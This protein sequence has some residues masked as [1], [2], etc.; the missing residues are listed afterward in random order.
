MSHVKEG[1]RKKH[2]VRKFLV[3]LLLLLILIVGGGSLLFY[4]ISGITIREC[5]EEAESIAEEMTEDSFRLNSTTSIYYADGSL[6]AE[7]R[8]EASSHY[9][10]YEEIPE[11]AVNA[12]VAIEDRTFWEN[13]GYDV[14]GII[15]AGLSLLT[16]QEISQGGSTI[17]QQLCKLALLENENDYARKVKEIFLARNVTETYE[18]EQIMEWYI[19]Y[20]CYANN[21]YG[22]KDATEAYLGKSVDELTLSEICYLC[23]I[24][25]SPEY[26]DPWEYPDHAIERRDKILAAM[27]DEKMITEEEYAYAVTEE[28]EVKEETATGY[29]P[30]DETTYAI[31]CAAEI[32]M[33]ENGFSIENDFETMEEYEAYQ[34]AY[35]A[36]YEE[37]VGRLYTDGYTIHTSIIP[38]YQDMIQ[39]A[40]DHNLSSSTE[41][42]ENGIYNLQGAVTAVDNQT[43]KVI[44]IVG[45]RTQE[46]TDIINYNR[47]YQYYR[48]PGSS[49]KPLVVYTPALMMGYDKD[50]ILTNVDVQ[51]AYAVYKRGEAVTSLSG[52]SYTL[53]NAVT[54][55]RNGCAMVLYD[56]ITPEQ[57]LSY[58]LDMGFSRIVPDDYYLSSCLGGLTYGVNTVEMASA[59]SALANYGVYTK[60][61]CITSMV[62]PDGDELYQEPKQGTI[63]ERNAA[64]EMTDIME[65]VIQSGTA[66]GMNWDNASD[67]P[68]AGKTGT[69]N[70]DT[71]GWFCGYTAPY[72][73]AAWVGKDNNKTVD[74]LYGTYNPIYI[75]KD[76]MLGLTENYEGKNGIFGAK[77]EAE[78]GQ[79]DGEIWT[80]VGS[81]ANVRDSASSSS[82]VVFALPGGTKVQVIDYGED[83][84]KVLIDGKT[85]Y[86]YSPLLI[87]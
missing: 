37:A 38:E 46:G 42:S 20:C 53:Q 79:Q 81:G 29:T 36:A 16:E 34:E 51:S 77:K 35:D 52:P 76:V 14:K 59:Y 27:L 3:I 13:D 1:R 44:G 23:A 73:V 84:S 68:A 43:H 21:I 19:N 66:A 4:W 47:A 11:D 82:N 2:T 65:D 41:T 39:E 64:I 69:T 71:N 6:M 67:L 83:W 33:E 7:L 17:T 9:L 50:S 5:Y 40:I 24:P 55:S 15:R 78:E 10:E 18:K 54:W 45:R 74:G 22:L 31:S 12:F 62:S 86:I 63:Y 60:G 58:L 30:D 75:W 48:Q 28:I 25:N 49:I 32:L 70:D 87:R 26:Y 85:Y 61:D 8:K 72:T 57:G 80:V 56:E